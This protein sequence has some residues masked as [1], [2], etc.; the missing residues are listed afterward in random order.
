MVGNY[1]SGKSFL[2]TEKLAGT[3]H[4]MPAWDLLEKIIITFLILHLEKILEI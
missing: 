3:V 4:D 2:W 1:G